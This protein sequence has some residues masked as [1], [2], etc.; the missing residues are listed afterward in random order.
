MTERP[1]AYMSSTVAVPIYIPI[2]SVGGFPFLP[3]HLLFVDFFDDVTV[4]DPC[5]VIPH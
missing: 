4:S 3:T 2:N 1:N 5:D